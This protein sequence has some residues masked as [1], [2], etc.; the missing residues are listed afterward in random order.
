[1]NHHTASP[2]RTMMMM[3]REMHIGITGKKTIVI[4]QWKYTMTF[5]ITSN[6]KQKAL[7]ETVK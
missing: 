7:H 1:M 3:T 5:K 6:V 2:I 4:N